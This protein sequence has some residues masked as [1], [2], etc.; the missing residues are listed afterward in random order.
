MSCSVVFSIDYTIYPQPWSKK[1][2]KFKPRTHWSSTVYL[3]NRRIKSNITNCIIFK[4]RG[5]L[6]VIHLGKL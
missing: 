3:L 5:F 4:A 1:H 6:R 2:D